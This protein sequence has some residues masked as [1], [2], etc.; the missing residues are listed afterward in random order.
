MFIL[1]AIPLGVLAGLL[2]GGRFEGLSALRFR[3]APLA[4]AGFLAQVVLFSL[5]TSDLLEALGPAIYVVSTSA[6]LVAL[7]AN[8]QLTGLPLVAL[9][10]C[11]NLVAIL[12][13]GGQMPVR[14]A[15]LAAAGLDPHEGFSNSLITDAPVLEPLTDVFAL[16]PWLPFANVFSVGDVL[17]ALGI[18]V[19]I[20]AAMRRPRPSPPQAV[21]RPTVDRPA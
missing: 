12:A 18:A 15:T 2:S 6:V 7:I 20:A 21:Q 17:V 14:A 13:N 9:G 3:W 5:P 4:I 11:T 1:Y 8:L 16:P 19:A 10:A